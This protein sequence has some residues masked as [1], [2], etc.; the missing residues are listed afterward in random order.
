MRDIKWCNKISDEL[1]ITKID[2][3]NLSRINED[4]GN[5]ISKDFFDKEEV[6]KLVKKRDK[7][8]DKIKRQNK[9]LH[10]VFKE[11]LK[12]FKNDDIVK[13]MRGSRK[14]PDDVHAKVETFA[15]FPK[16]FANR[17]KQKEEYLRLFR[18][19]IEKIQRKRM[20]SYHKIILGAIGQQKFTDR[21]V[22]QLDWIVTAMPERT[23]RLSMKQ[24]VVTYALF[25]ALSLGALQG[26]AVGG[27]GISFGGGSAIAGEISPASRINNEGIR[28]YPV[29]PQL[30][31]F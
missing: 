23:I 21:V 26:L 31:N 11:A 1:K 27:D 10:K 12:T 14:N 28:L 29:S 4:I 16:R 24:K 6:L 15:D 20:L 2:T 30:I 8:Y 18:I 22:A 5:L 9:L 19:A 13:Q 17:I 7:I 25:F 3:N